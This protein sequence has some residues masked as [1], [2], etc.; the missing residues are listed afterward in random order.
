MQFLVFFRRL[1]FLFQDIIDLS[2][3]VDSV[4]GGVAEGAER[5]QGRG[6]GGGGERRDSSQCNEEFAPFIAVIS[7]IIIRQS[8]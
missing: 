4:G 2:S 3:P 8:L 6:E 1:L 5:R 7:I